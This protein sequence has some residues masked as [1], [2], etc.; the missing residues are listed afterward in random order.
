[1]QGKPAASKRAIGAIAEAPVARAAAVSGQ[2]PSKVLGRGAF[3]D[4][5]LT[6]AFADVASYSKVVLPAS[7]HAELTTLALKHAVVGRNDLAGDCL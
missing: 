3:Q 7:D 2:V 5:D 4:V 6:A 1:V